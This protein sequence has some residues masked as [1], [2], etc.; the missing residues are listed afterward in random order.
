[1]T[2]LRAEEKGALSTVA[3]EL[4]VEYR[5]IISTDGLTNGL[6]EAQVVVHVVSAPISSTCSEPLLNR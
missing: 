5:E 2:L 6:E 1:M 4:I 3:Y